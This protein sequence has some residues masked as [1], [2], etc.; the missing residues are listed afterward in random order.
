MRI[1]GIYK[2]NRNVGSQLVR[3]G[4]TPEGVDSVDWPL[5]LQIILGIAKQEGHEIDLFLPNGSKDNGRLI[6]FNPDIVLYSCMTNQFPFVL[7]FHNGLRGVKPN[8]VS[9]IGGYHPSAKPDVVKDGFNYAVI[10]EGEQTFRELLKGITSENRDFSNISG[11]SFLR[12][13]QLV[14]TPRRERISNLDDLPEPYINDSLLAQKSNYLGYPSQRI[15]VSGYSEFSRGCT[16]D[17]NFC[18]SPNVLGRKLVYRSPEKVAKHW[19]EQYEKYGINDLFLTDLNPTLNPQKLERLSD[20]LIEEGIN[21]TVSWAFMSGFKNIT[22]T[23]LRKLSEGGSKFICWGLENVTQPSWIK[24]ET[25]K[26]PS[27]EAMRETL[28]CSESNG[29]MNEGFYIIGWP[30]ET[31]QD[32]ERAMETLPLLPLHMIR[33]SIY[34]PLP[35]AVN[36]DIAEK[37]GVLTETNFSKYDTQHL[38]F[39][40]PNF[41][42]GE[43][44]GLQMEFLKRFYNHPTYKTRVS[45]F[46]RINP[47]YKECFDD[48]LGIMQKYLKSV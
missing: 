2:T 30:N 46:V 6:Q 12:D 36:F 41:S 27:I 8:L 4:E 34:T 39:K 33:P 45:E 37:Q 48:F 3:T 26:L 19:R 14:V 10:G 38:V 25:R 44:E 23:L 9:V 17:C 22:P 24:D 1:A 40:H 5:G 42:Q 21:E 15:R 18:A 7:D 32:L 16:F 20:A 29:I 47:Q 28:S 35:G 43:L 11:I 31:R 13:G